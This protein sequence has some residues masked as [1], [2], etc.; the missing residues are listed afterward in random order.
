MVGHCLNAEQGGADA[1]VGSTET[2][3]LARVNTE[4]LKSIKMAIDLAS[5]EK[6]FALMEDDEKRGFQ[7]YDISFHRKIIE[8][9]NYYIK[10][11]PNKIQIVET[12]PKCGVDQN[13]MACTEY[14]SRSIISIAKEHAS[15]AFRIELAHV[16][17]HELG[18]H[19]TLGKSEKTL[20]HQK[21]EKG[22]NFVDRIAELVLQNFLLEQ[23]D[24]YNRVFFN[25]QQQIGAALISDKKSV[26]C[27]IATKS[28]LREEY[29]KKI[30]LYIGS[31]ELKSWNAM[32]SDGIVEA[33][34]MAKE[35]MSK[36]D[37][38]LI[39]F[40]NNCFSAG[41]SITCW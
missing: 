15:T 5:P 6:I 4:F 28:K 39:E 33:E 1:G 24:N 37:C 31:V 40:K 18:H 34:E 25:E 3:L 9:I 10:E 41:G 26:T 22:R 8:E 19:I 30:R 13:V 20:G 7:F 14:K 2:I 16:I 29:F 11:A 12:I 21:N 36:G 35:K 23:S 38:S 27:T 17:I 32:N